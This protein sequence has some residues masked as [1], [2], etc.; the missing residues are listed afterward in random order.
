MSIANVDASIIVGKLI[1][2]FNTEEQNEIRHKNMFELIKKYTFSYMKNIINNSN[3]FSK[4]DKNIV[5]KKI[6]VLE[7][8][9]DVNLDITEDF[10]DYET[11]INNIGIEQMN[12]LVYEDNGEDGESDSD[13]DKKN[14]KMNILKN[15]IKEFYDEIGGEKLQNMFNEVMESYNKNNDEDKKIINYNSDEMQDEENINDYNKIKNYLNK[16]KKSN[17]KLKIKSNKKLNKHLK[18][19]EKEIEEEFFEEFSEEETNNKT[20]NETNNETNKKTLYDELLDAQKNATEFTAS[21]EEILLGY[22]T[23]VLPDG[24]TY[25]GQVNHNGVQHGNGIE[26]DHNGNVVYEG[27]YINGIKNGFGIFYFNNR[28]KI[29]DVIAKYM[30]LFE[31]ESFTGEGTIYKKIN[32]I[33]N[34]DKSYIE[35]GMIKL[36]EGKFKDGKALNGNLTLLTTDMR[37]LNYIG[38]VCPNDG[39]LNFI[40][41]GK[42]S[43]YE[44]DV[45]IEDGTYNMGRLNGYGKRLIEGRWF[46]GYFNNGSMEGIFDSEDSNYTYIFKFSKN[47]IISLI[48]Q[49]EKVPL[50]REELIKREMIENK[51]YK[52]EF[53]AII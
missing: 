37:I 45:L 52:N 15:T 32:N 34:I 29:G 1:K 3:T 48:D 21:A 2:T 46:N 13:Y 7:E 16:N 24:R 40:N 33:T 43:I 42:G 39:F 18:D 12:D 41:N 31:N 4:K 11:F 47:K 28:N 23:F 10:K 25:S 6:K 49:K 53:K 14:F 51:Y 20:N 38:D 30:G 19:E 50:T 44:N 35:D 5:K 36:F 17:K 9:V 26:M 22:G 27:S 8:F